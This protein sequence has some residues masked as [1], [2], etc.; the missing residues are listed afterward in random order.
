MSRV[1]FFTREAF[2]AL[3]RNAAPSIAAT[4]TVAVTVV[5]IGVLVPVIFAAQGKTQDVREQIGLKVFLTDG[6]KPEQINA[7]RQRIAGTPNVESVEYISKKDAVPILEERL[8]DEDALAQ[9]RRNPL[10]ASFTVYPDDPNQLEAVQAALQPVN[11]Q[12]RPQPISPIIDEVNAS[13]Q[14]AAPIREVTSGLQVWLLCIAI[15]L[16]FTS[17]LLVANTIRLSIYSRRRDIE[18]MRLVGATGWFIRWPFVIEGILVGFLG[19]IIAVAFLWLGKLI[20]SDPLTQNFAFID[21]LRTVAFVPLIL[22]LL[23]GSMV[24]AAIGSGFTLRR[25]LRV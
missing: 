23:A 21:D 16:G 8:G 25:F 18:V 19:A 6:A 17:L 7:L 14:D 13:R 20:V 11:A 12:G 24:V 10:P 9:L 4:V 3:R 1:L 5:L 15:L 22:L 2:T